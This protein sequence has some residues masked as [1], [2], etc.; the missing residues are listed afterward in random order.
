MENLKTLWQLLQEVVEKEDR[1][2]SLYDFLEEENRYARR[3]I[4][5][6]L[7]KADQKQFYEFMDWY[8]FVNET[9]VY[10]A[11]C[12]Y[13]EKT[14]DRPISMWECGDMSDVADDYIRERNLKFDDDEDE[15]I[16]LPF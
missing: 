15:E 6:K 4:K 8:T 14:M 5:E 2:F 7:E 3:D 13:Y 10:M 1:Y 16:I 12:E 11:V 9:E